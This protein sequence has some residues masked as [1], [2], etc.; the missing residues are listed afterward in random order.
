[1]Y[2]PPLGGG[3]NIGQNGI[4]SELLLWCWGGWAVGEGGGGADL[5]ADR[6]SFAV[7]VVGGWVGPHGGVSAE[8]VPSLQL[9]VCHKSV[10]SV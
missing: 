6:T 4:G 7:V 5:G 10:C 3:G 9:G 1:M 2:L 8:L